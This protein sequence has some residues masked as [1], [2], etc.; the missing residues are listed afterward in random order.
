MDYGYL[1]DFDSNLY[2][3]GAMEVWACGVLADR[4]VY[5][6]LPSLGSYALDGART[7][8][9]D[10]NDVEG[11]WCADTAPAT[12]PPPEALGLPGTPQEA[13]RPCL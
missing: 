9:A 7:P 1:S 5:R 13:N 11:Y 8:T 2:D 10:D 6:D 12:A 3:G 4:V